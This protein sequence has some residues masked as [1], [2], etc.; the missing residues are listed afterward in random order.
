MPSKKIE[1]FSITH[2]E[3][4][5]EEGNVDQELEPDLSDEKLWELYGH[6]AF[7][8]KSDERMLN[9][10]RQG[11]IGTFG[12][13][14]GQ[15]AS[16]CGSVFALSEKDWVVFAFRE[17]GAQL[18]R[19]A[20][21]TNILLMYNGYEEGNVIPKGG[22]TLPMSI[23]VGSQLPHAAGIGYA[24]KYKGEK[25]SAV[26]VYFGDGATSQGD[27]HEALNFAAVWDAPVIFLC[28]NNQWAISVP[29]TKQTRSK[30]LAQKALA[31][32]I[33]GV[34]V[35]GNDV[36]AVYR[37]VSDAKKRA[38]EGK[39]PTLIEAETYRLMMHTTADDPTKYRKQEDVDEWWK[40]EPLT[41]FRKYL[42]KK[43]IWTEEKE[44]ELQ[45]SVKKR[46]DEAVKELESEHDFKPDSSFDHVFGTSHDEIEQ[47]RKEF[48]EELRKEADNG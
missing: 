10:Q 22:R 26:I 31:Y 8:R 44:K 29:R 19:G 9:L 13:A 37:A 25:D 48:L 23:I 12:P 15:E 11:R 3:V 6:M 40:K 21:L 34:Q 16:A 17:L 7:A 43:G 45:D 14:T 28:Q 35:D 39:G 46:I 5:D 41:R 32:G 20:S 2:L 36:L 18:M 30:T 38:Y 33:P 47:Q 1:D 24:M 4:L 27:F 42:E